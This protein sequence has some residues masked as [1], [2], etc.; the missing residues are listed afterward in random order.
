M[1]ISKKKKKKFV[2]KSKKLDFKKVNDYITEYNKLSN[3][4]LI[5][6]SKKILTNLNNKDTK[7]KSELNTKYLAL[8]Y[9]SD[10]RLLNTYNY[11]YKFKYYPDYEDPN[12]NKKIFEKKEFRINKINKLPEMSPEEREILS[13]KKCNPLSSTNLPADKIKFKLTQNQKFLKSF[14]SPNTPY[15]SL[16][17]FHGTGVGK[18]CSSISIVEQFS[19]ELKKYGKKITVLMKPALEENFRKNIFDIRKVVAGTPNLQCTRDKYLKELKTTDLPPEKINKKINK[20]IKSRY[21]FTG[22]QEFANK[23]N[24]IINKFQSQYPKEKSENLINLEIKKLYSNSVMIIDEAHNIKEGSGVKILPPILYRV[25]RNADNMKLLLLT[26]TPMFDNP[27][28][29]V[30]LINLLLTNDKRSLLKEDDFF[31]K[32]GAFRK[33]NQDLFVKRITGY[34]SYMRGEDPIRFPERR[35]PSLTNILEPANLSNRNKNNVIIPINKRIRELKLYGCVMKGFQKQVYDMMERGDDPRERTKFGNF[36][37]K[38]IQTSIIVYPKLTDSNNN[39]DFI[40]DQHIGDVGFDSIVKKSRKY[41]LKDSFKGFFNVDNLDNYSCKISQFIK[42]ITDSEGIIFVYSKYIKS[43]I[44]PL[45][46]ALEYNGY[47]KYDGSLIAEKVDSIGKYIILSGDEELSPKNTYKNYLN[48]QKD[49]KNG[50]KVKII[51]GTETAAEGLDFKYIRQVHILE[52][53]FHLNKIEQIIGR[54]IRNCSHIDLDQEKRNVLIF[55]YVALKSDTPK[56]DTETIDLE[57]YRRAELKSREMGY[58]EYIIKRSAVDCSLN[59]H[60]NIFS[61]DVDYSKKCNYEKCNFKCLPDL[62]DLVLETNNNTLNR[63]A[64]I[65]NLLFTE[66]LIMDI[67]EDNPY[68]YLEEILELIEMDEKIVYMALDKLVEENRLIYRNKVYLKSDIDSNILIGFSN[69]KTNKRKTKPIGYNISKINTFVKKNISKEINISNDLDYKKITGIIIHENKKTYSDYIERFLDPEV[70]SSIRPLTYD[71]KLNYKLF[72]K[73]LIKN[74][75]DVLIFTKL[76]DDWNM[77]KNYYIDFLPLDKKELYIRYLILNQ[78]KLSTDETLILL[79]C[80]NIIKKDGKIW[81]YKILRIDKKKQMLFFKLNGANFVKA[82]KEEIELL[83]RERLDKNETA[84]EPND[85]IGFLEY[86][87]K[88]DKIVFKLRSKTEEGVKKTQIKTGSICDNDGTK[89]VKVIEYIHQLS[90]ILFNMKLLGRKY[91]NEKKE[92]ITKQ[93]TEFKKKKKTKIK[94]PKLPNPLTKEFVC[95][96]CK[97]LLMYKDKQKDKKKKYFYNVEESYELLNKK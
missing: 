14:I 55:L 79:R 42:N 57:L 7:N 72:N 21:N 97:L 13:K 5:I 39:S 11:P 43:G 33:E 70:D 88:D 56:S 2:K 68:L 66:D 47:Q 30:W 38:G 34:I 32:S 48:I 31:T 75:Q 20:I 36:N 78:A 61:G 58:V 76:N 93:I 25:L 19:D 24:R 40:I 49:N 18:T 96:L 6:E 71:E 64:V 52:P 44:L 53:W 86:K 69:L 1:D 26:A 29:I 85:I 59:K 22:Y 9:I 73:I 90:D 37:M 95:N 3:N 81:G 15:N 92:E 62:D 46:L 50:E 89:I 4:E 74:L 28:E 23:I 54:A 80:Y 87:K 83:E 91:W 16:L 94:V 45:A 65:E 77:L 63:D 67:F 27:R 10:K 82:T 51:I 84:L 41:S 35:Y 8:K 12:F 17:L 60:G